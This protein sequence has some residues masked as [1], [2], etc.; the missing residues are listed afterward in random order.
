MKQV[1]STEICKERPNA[2]AIGAFNEAFSFGFFKTRKDLS[3][4]NKVANEESKQREI[5]KAADA[6]TYRKSSIEFAKNQTKNYEANISYYESLLNDKSPFRVMSDTDIKKNIRR[7]K[8]DLT[9]HKKKNGF[10]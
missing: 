10:R 9:K 4:A 3:T 2:A 7:L 5:K 1:L 8:T 6:E